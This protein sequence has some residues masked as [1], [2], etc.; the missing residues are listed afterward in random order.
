MLREPGQ[1]RG[2]VCY[3][4]AS[5]ILAM[6]PALLVQRLGC[7]T[8]PSEALGKA[9]GEFVAKDCNNTYPSIIGT[10]QCRETS[11]WTCRAGEKSSEWN[12]HSTG[13]SPRTNQASQPPCAQEHA[14]RHDMAHVQHA[15][16]L[17]GQPPDR[18]RP[19]HRQHH[20]QC[21]SA[22]KWYPKPSV[23]SHP[24]SRD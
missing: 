11:R 12:E 23:H 7:E 21:T 5:R 20:E 9:I 16:I 19:S 18:R 22:V 14:K 13:G 2:M 3:T 4:T 1:R 6:A 24:R 17:T 15:A 10:G 8:T